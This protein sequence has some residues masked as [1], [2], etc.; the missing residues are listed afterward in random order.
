[1]SNTSAADRHTSSTAELI[2]L[3]RKAAGLT[4][5][6]LAKLVG[7]TQ[8]DISRWEAGIHT[9]TVAILKKIA[10]A[11]DCAVSDLV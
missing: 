6:Q 4:Q 11:L 9:P 10:A 1:M 2:R 8:V 7:C 3:R 5:V